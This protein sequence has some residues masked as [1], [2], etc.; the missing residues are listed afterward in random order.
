MNLKYTFLAINFLFSALIILCS[1]PLPTLAQKKKSVPSVTAQVP[2]IPEYLTIN[3]DVPIFENQDYRYVQTVRTQALPDNGFAMS[4]LGQDKKTRFIFLNKNDIQNSSKQPLTTAK[5]TIT[6]D[7]A[8]VHSFVIHDK[9]LVY[10][11]SP[12][13]EKS[14]TKLGYL[15]EPSLFICK[16]TLSGK[17]IFAK[18]LVN[19]STMKMLWNREFCRMNFSNTGSDGTQ[20]VWT[21]KFYSVIFP[22]FTHCQDNVNHQMDS[23]YIID[24]VGTIKNLGGMQGYAN[25]WAWLTSHSFGQRLVYSPYQSGNLIAVSANDGYPVRAINVHTLNTEKILLAVTTSTADKVVQAFTGSKDQAPII[26]VITPFDGLGESL[27]QL[28]KNVRLDKIFQDIGTAFAKPPQEAG[29]F[30]NSTEQD[31]DKALANSSTQA[32]VKVQKNTSN[33]PTTSAKPSKNQTKQSA[34]IKKVDTLQ[35]ALQ[36]KQSQQLAAKAAAD[37]LKI[38]QQQIQE[39]QIQEQNE[40]R[41]ADSL[42]WEYSFNNASK[43]LLLGNSLFP[44]RGAS[45]DNYIANTQLGDIIPTPTGAV[46]TFCS[47]EKRDTVKNFAQDVCWMKINTKGRLES[48]RWLTFTPQLA[49]QNVHT[50]RIGNLN[51]F[52]VIWDVFLP[53][54][55]GEF[56]RCEQESIFSHS[57]YVIVDEDGQVI[58]SEKIFDESYKGQSLEITHRRTR[59]YNC[60]Q[61]TNKD[62]VMLRTT[63]DPK[64]LD[65]LRFTLK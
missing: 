62:V 37:S 39:Q 32:T 61:L 54:T 5:S 60:I 43:D 16:M 22:H 3:L 33:Q 47:A 8:V 57:E 64:E 20:I 27:G 58:R 50:S 15:M 49:E 59:S 11:Y 30:T 21:G 31:V 40:Q 63:K 36:V 44:I 41:K 35:A 24:T 51:L 48:A 2:N 23:W 29:V 13:K 25:G 14:Q 42:M 19:D 45:G 52:I 53:A 28:F 18:P 55:S 9:Y 17:Q 65:L 4:Y 1:L 26:K 56:W 46:F 38:R 10:L 7:S 34:P 6:I 12:I